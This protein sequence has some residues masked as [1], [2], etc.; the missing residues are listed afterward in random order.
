MTVTRLLHGGSRNEGTVCWIM[1]DASK[2]ELVERNR[3][4]FPIEV[5]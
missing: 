3:C 1:Q 5:L 4:V 2:N